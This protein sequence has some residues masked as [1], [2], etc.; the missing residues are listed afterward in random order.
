MAHH[1]ASRRS[2]WRAATLTIALV[3]IAT[4]A[5]GPTAF[6]QE[7]PRSVGD[8]AGTVA[9]V[10]PVVL[11][12]GGDDG[13]TSFVPLV[14][15][16][17]GRAL[18]RLSDIVVT[19]HG[20]GPSSRAA[21]EYAVGIW[22]R[23]VRSPVPIRVDA[24]WTSMPS[25]AVGSAGSNGVIR[26]FAG[27]PRPSTF[28]P[29]ALADAKA[30][31]DLYP[32]RSDIV[33]NFNKDIT[34][35]Y[36]TD[37]VTEGN[38][39]LVSAA[40]H[41]IGHGLG[42]NSSFTVSGGIGGYGVD[43]SRPTVY[44]RFLAD[45]AGASLLSGN[46]SSAL[47]SRLQ[48]NGVRFNGGQAVSENGGTVRIYSPSPFRQGSSMSHLDEASYPR[49]DVD[50]LMTPF[51]DWGEAVHDPGNTSLG[52]LRDIGWQTTSSR[53]TKPAAPT[54]SRVSAGNG[55]VDV[56]WSKPTSPARG[57][58]L[59]YVVHQYTNGSSTASSTYPVPGNRTSL[60]VTGLQNGTT[61]RFKVTAQNL[62]GTSV[63]SP[64]SAAA[65]PLVLGPFT[66]VDA[67]LNREY[68][69]VLFRVPSA[70]SMASRR[71]AV[72]TGVDTPGETVVAL[73]GDATHTRSVP[74]TIRLYLAYFKRLPDEGGLAYW[75]GKARGGTS[76][77][78]ASEQFAR[79]SEF[80]RA[81]GAVSNGAFVDLVYQN[82]L[83][84]AP[85]SGGRTYWIR[86][87]NAGFPR[88]SVMIN[89]SESSEN[90]RKTTNTVALVGLYHVLLRRIPTSTE[91]D[92]A[93]S[94]LGT[95]TRLHVIAG[96]ILLSPEYAAR[97]N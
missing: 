11:Y 91:L 57:S 75:A 40:L 70:A 53:F 58:I 26:D 44:D 67:F 7:A 33:A 93:A 5:S 54:I 19:Y 12:D 94:R 52:V 42:M 27:A 62:A 69:D 68:L 35:N 48:S 8:A 49:G 96:E 17:E 10:E 65:K 22:E 36:S 31:H 73:M 24:T 86:K 41:E 56:A 89:V 1:M 3:T 77:H 14:D 92:G 63:G 80:T 6:A 30:G 61:Y 51:I 55:R 60:S 39:D 25:G 37:G 88:G 45:S 29:M 72:N 78:K 15:N 32:G 28:Y 87:L 76:L 82:V 23:M 85:D 20:F 97:I 95:G 2:H 84:R 4:L 38:I 83:G 71:N 47:G 90:V 81:Y 59:Q 74:P 16:A 66:N 64:T 43:G 46:G 34:W 9:G 18:P 50:S 13:T 79:S 21:F